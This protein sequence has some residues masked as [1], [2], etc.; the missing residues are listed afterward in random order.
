FTFLI[1]EEMPLVAVGFGAYVLLGKRDWKLGSGVI[2][3]GLL[4]FFA[5][6][7]QVIP[8]FAEGRSYPYIAERYGAVG[9]SAAGILRTLVTDPA[10]IS[11]SVLQPKK[12]L[13]LF[14][15]FGPVAGLSWV[16]GWAALVLLPTLGYL[17][18]SSYEPQFSF[19]SQYSAPLVPLVIGT[20]ILGLARAPIRFQPA[21]A[22]VMVVSSLAFSWAFGYMPYSRKFDA[23]QFRTD[24]V[25]RVCAEVVGH[26]TRRACFR[27]NGTHQ[28]PVRAALRLR[29]PVRGGAGCRMGGARL[30]GE[31]LQ[32]GEI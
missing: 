3:A 18:L 27:R 28:P 22:A 6:I 12:I 17:L 15:I 11:A 5:L 14:G 32:P 29:L 9:G 2:A 31:R 30:R 26:R 21:L 25:R 24:A 1:K 23:G 20:A 19:T 8:Y 16:S 7:S 13:F 10:R 4:S